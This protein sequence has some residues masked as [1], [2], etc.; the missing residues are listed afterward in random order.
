MEFFPS[1]LQDINAEIFS[2]SSNTLGDIFKAWPQVLAALGI[3]I[4]GYIIMRFIQ[5]FIVK[6]SRKIL[7][8]TLSDQSGFTRFLQK[9]KIKSGP[10]QVIANFIG[11]Y[12]FTLFFLAASN[13]L[14][15]KDI[16]IFLDKV[17]GYIPNIIVALFIVLIG[18]QIAHTMSAI[19]ESTLNIMESAA[20]RV[21]GLVAKSIIIIFSI[22]AAFIQLNIAEDLITILFIGVVATLSLAVGLSLGLG[23]KDFIADILK[24]INKK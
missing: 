7:L 15:L 2:S 16:S 20:A 8:H 21:V 19:V 23:S 1:Q 11:G 17:M 4:V 22:L 9:A 3:I 6:I 10:S 13:I 14:G 5:W 24:N 12:V 18:F